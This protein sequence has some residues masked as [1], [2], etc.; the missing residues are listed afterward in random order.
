MLGVAGV[1][2]RWLC[3]LKFDGFAVA[4]RLEEFDLRVRVETKWLCSLTADG[5]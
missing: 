3:S 2:I 4:C 5:F 1:G